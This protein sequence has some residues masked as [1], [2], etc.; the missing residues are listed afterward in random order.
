M[1][2]LSGTSNDTTIVPMRLLA[3]HLHKHL[4]VVY[5]L[6]QD[7]CVLL[8]LRVVSCNGSASLVLCE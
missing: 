5:D 8:V 2:L 6:R 4:T 1:L 7:S 3:K